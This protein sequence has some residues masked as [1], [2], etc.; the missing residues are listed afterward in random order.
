MIV[1]TVVGNDSE[2][3]SGQ[4]LETKRGYC[5]SSL[6]TNRIKKKTRK[7]K[8]KQKSAAPNLFATQ[9]TTKIFTSE[10]VLLKINYNN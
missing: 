9:N 7:S 2:L 10:H 1:E 8:T 5:C 3:V 6:Q 4:R